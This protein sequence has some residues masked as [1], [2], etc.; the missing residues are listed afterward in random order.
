MRKT[1][2]LVCLCCLSVFG[3]SAHTTAPNGTFTYS[4]IQYWVGTGTKQTAFVVVFNDGKTPNAL[5]WGYRYDGNKSM[6]DMLQE[7]AAT[8]SR[9]YYMSNTSF[10]TLGGVGYNANENDVFSLQKD[11][12]TIQAVN[13][14]FLVNG[15]EYDGYTPTETEDR[16]ISGWMSGGYFFLSNS[17]FSGPVAENDWTCITFSL[18]SGSYETAQSATY[19]AV[20]PP[21]NTGVCNSPTGLR[22]ERMTS[23]ALGSPVT[24]RPFMPYL[25]WTEHD[26]G[27]RI[28]YK[29]TQDTGWTEIS[30][31]DTNRVSIPGLTSDAEYQWKVCRV[32]ENNILSEWT[33]GTNFVT[34]LPEGTAPN[35][36]FT[37]D[38]ILFWVGSG[39]NRGAVVISFSDDLEPATLVWGVKW[40]GTAT[41]A[42]LLDT[43][44]TY[45]S[46]LTV[47]ISNDFIQAISYNGEDGVVRPEGVT[48]FWYLSEGM[49]SN[50]VPENIWAGATFAPRWDDD[51][52]AKSMARQEHYTPVTPIATPSRCD[53]PTGLH[54]GAYTLTTQILSWQETEGMFEVQYKMKDAAMWHSVSVSDT[55]SVR[56]TS[57]H[58][59]TVYNW[60]L[61]K[62]CAANDTSEWVNGNDFDNTLPEN[63]APNGIFTLNDIQYWA[64]SGEHQS[65]FVLTFNDNKDPITL[66]WGVRWN[67]NFNFFNLLDT[68]DTYDPRFFYMKDNSGMVQG[69]GFDANE[70]GIFGVVD[71]GTVTRPINGSFGNVNEPY[72]TPE[73]D[74]DRWQGGDV[75]GFWYLS[76]GAA[77]SNISD[78][79]WV[80]AT[81]NNYHLPVNVAS[82][83]E[84]TTY[85]AVTPASQ[86]ECPD[87]HITEVL[88]ITDS[89]A[90]IKWDSGEGNFELHYRKEGDEA[91]SRILAISNA[92]TFRLSSLQMN[93]TYEIQVRRRCSDSNVGAWSEAYNFTTLHVA[94][95]V[96]TESATEVDS[97]SATLR[98]VIT[99]GSDEITGRGFEW[100]LSTENVFTPVAVTDMGEM[101]SY[102]LT[103][104]QPD[105]NYSYRAYIEVSGEK[106]YGDVQHFTTLPLGLEPVLLFTDMRLYPNPTTYQVTVS[107]NNVEG[108][109]NLLLLDVNGRVVWNEEVFSN[110]NAATKSIDVSHLPKGTY[111]FHIR[112]ESKVAT[113]KLIVQ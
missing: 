91:Y 24:E 104:L 40:N 72:G 111:Y 76:N 52:L 86:T 85:T 38:S 57:L 67:G 20:L 39:S 55:N 77:A 6:A 63:T 99:A 101:F 95:T 89:S 4:D 22:L 66:V 10:S 58:S 44:T 46:R 30:V 81:W 31:I 71:N 83:H 21:Q 93:T 9:F 11:G 68:L 32:C 94:S 82:F 75:D 12:N 16:W 54:R 36:I 33:N 53:T 5:V 106:R 34:T 45:D 74:E 92:D 100:K 80:G 47:N 62:I 50:P 65:A 2:I 112:N 110:N 113:Q 15:Y 96:I 13:N 3:I 90:L 59:D 26:G 108:V 56:L 18:Y 105:M 70:N 25:A 49:S 28:A 87:V 41:F 42:H 78:K 69:I 98:A 1:L 29:Q 107:V 48:G 14:L 19:T 35:G 64:G 60:R 109:V 97:I 37:F 7:I 79:Q 102:V 8:D 23:Y 51:A 84:Y 17:G 88:D 103:G 43:I 27:F 61:R 73:E